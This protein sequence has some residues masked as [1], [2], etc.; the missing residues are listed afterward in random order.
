MTITAD[1]NT[2]SY[3]QQRKRLALLILDG[4]TLAFERGGGWILWE[5]LCVDDHMRRFFQ[6]MFCGFSMLARSTELAEANPFGIDYLEYNPYRWLHCFE[7]LLCYTP[8]N[9]DALKFWI[10]RV[11][12]GIFGFTAQFNATAV[13]SEA[14]AWG[15]DEIFPL[16]EPIFPGAS[17]SHGPPS[18]Q[19]PREGNERRMLEIYGIHS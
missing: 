1:L 9:W 2:L 3:E 11:P 15:P 8:H 17:L 5:A 13:Y 4:T 10:Q 12:P 16:L 7:E 19:R 18:C 6:D 14:I